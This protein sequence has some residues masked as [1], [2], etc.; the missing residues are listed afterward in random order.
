MQTKVSMAAVLDS[1]NKNIQYLFNNKYHHTSEKL[2]GSIVYEIN[3]YD[4]KLQ[5]RKILTTVM[6]DICL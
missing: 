3:K 6:I 1:T 5:I 2:I 4:I